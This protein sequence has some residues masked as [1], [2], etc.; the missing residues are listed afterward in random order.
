MRTRANDTAYDSS[1]DRMNVTRA[2]LERMHPPRLGVEA[3]S[4]GVAL[5]I[6]RASG[7]IAAE[8]DESLLPRL[9]EELRDTWNHVYGCG[10][11][12]GD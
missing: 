4:R 6:A 10:V 2:L 11:N 1:W 8:A 12:R 7:S 5:W 3:V 9:L